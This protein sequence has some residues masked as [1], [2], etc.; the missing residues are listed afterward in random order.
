MEGL[1]MAG[2]FVVRQ[3]CDEAEQRDRTVKCVFTDV[4]GLQ[5]AVKESSAGFSILRLASRIQAWQILVQQL[6]A[7][8]IHDDEGR[9]NIG[10][11]LG[12][13]VVRLNVG[14][15]YMAR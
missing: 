7:A 14:F 10:Y 12:F 8:K 15:T 11:R 3:R 1:Q 4:I 9:G 6:P 13:A 5:P 2:K